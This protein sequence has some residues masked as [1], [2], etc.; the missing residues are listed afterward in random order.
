ME[1]HM[2]LDLKDPKNW[3]PKEVFESYCGDKSDKLLSFY[4]K[5]AAKGKMNSFS[6]NWLAILLLPAWLGYRK[7]WSILIAITVIFAGL[8]FLEAI[9]SISIPISGFMGGLIAIGLLANSLL[10]MNAQKEYHKLKQRGM[11]NEDIKNQLNNK[12]SPSVQYAVLGFLGYLVITF[13]AATI[14]DIVF[15]LPY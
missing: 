8:P 3:I 14:A 4:D 13:G 9:L 5:A 1:M 12:V 10:L 2:K 15:G 7:Q 11:D 6:L